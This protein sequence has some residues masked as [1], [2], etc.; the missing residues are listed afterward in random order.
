VVFT[1]SG[2]I[3][4]VSND[5][6]PRLSLPYVAAG[7]AQ[8][9]VTVN[10]GL[11]R[12]DA[13]VQLAVES[14]SLSAA[15]ANP[16]DGSLYILSAAGTGSGWSGQPAGSLM[17]YE[18]GSWSLVPVCEGMLAWLRNDDQLLVH[19]GSQWQVFSS[20]L[21]VLNN[22]DRLGVGTSA[23]A[24]NPL[25][26][27]LNK[28]LF[29]AKPVAEGGDGGLRYTLNKETS[30]A[31]LSFLMQSAWSGRAELG[32]IGSDDLSLKVSSDGSNW[33]TALS[34]DRTSGKVSFAKGAMLSQTDIFTASGTYS[35][36]SWARRLEITLIGGGGGGASGASGDATANRLGGGGGGAGALVTEDYNLEALTT[37]LSLSVGA[38]GLGGAGTTGT[39]SGNVGGN[40]GATSLV[41]AGV[42][43][44]SASG[45]SGGTVVGGLGGAG[46]FGL[47]ASGG[48]SIAT[49]TA[50]SGAAGLGAGPGAGGAGGA[51]DTASAARSGGTGGG[52]YPIGGAGRASA[53]GAVGA[54][55]ATKAW[56]QGSGAGGGGSSASATALPSIAG[57][58]GAP[59]GGGGGGGATRNTL[60]SAKGG[61]GA[62]GEI[63]ITA[64]G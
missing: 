40:G 58:G 38:G 24:T 49:G 20:L 19:D 18:A 35:P 25:S 37:P 44:L 63:W 50:G 34:V 61:D 55:G 56:A 16:V 31:V 1:V 33:Q 47:A 29:T 15:P 30:N 41:S 6:S 12:L 32:L 2:E 57:S 39:S 11:S 52:G 59:G 23:D 28:A 7:Q 54:S 51:L 13:I 64:I 21:K 10:E 48:T 60:T 26:V 9:H 27:R 22:L 43:I 3:F 62:R 53:G 45:G 14:R 42:V 36:P 5:A 4:I 46:G 17:R 8:K